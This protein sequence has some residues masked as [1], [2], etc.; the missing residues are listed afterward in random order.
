MSLKEIL[1]KCG[2][3]CGQCSSYLGEV[4]DL[5]SQ[6]LNC[7]SEDYSWLKDNKAFDFDNFVKGLDYFV[8]HTDCLGCRNKKEIWCDVMKCPKIQNDKLDNCLICDE[9]SDCNL[10]EYQKKRYSY[11]YNHIKI[12]KDKGLDKFLEQEQQK[13][14]D[15]LRLSDIRDY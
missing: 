7:V 9:F 14:N 8:H 2:V 4:S 13:S 10:N 5:A 11:L 12:I 1:G 3:Y 6:L 15:G